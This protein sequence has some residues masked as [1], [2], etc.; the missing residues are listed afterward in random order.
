MYTISI[1]LPDLPKG[2]EIDVDG[3]GKFENGSVNDISDELAESFRVHHATIATELGEG[4]SHQNSIVLGR[5]I[6]EAF[7]NNPNITVEKASKAAPVVKPAKDKAVVNP[8]GS[9][10]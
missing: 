8:E 3:L 6:E 10:N 7:E 4:G 5:S 9:E 1:D 2:T